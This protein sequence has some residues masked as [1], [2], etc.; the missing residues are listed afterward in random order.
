MIEKSFASLVIIGVLLLGAMGLS[1]VST[2]TASDATGATQAVNHTKLIVFLPDA[3]SGWVRKV[4]GTSI[5]SKGWSVAEGTYNVSSNH[6]LEGFDAFVGILDYGSNVSEQ[7]F[8]DRCPEFT[9]M[10][11]KTV[12]VKGF[13]AREQYD[14]DTNHYILQVNINNRF[15][16]V[17]VTNRG[18]DTLYEFADAIDYKGIVALGRDTEYPAKSTEVGKTPGFELGLV[19][20]SVMTI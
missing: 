7:E 12:T 16:V 9:N 5:V 2:T 1:I 3:P 11:T 18:K 10:E 6:D 4:E 13:Q 15:V 14:K 20:A 19:I 8:W 17:I